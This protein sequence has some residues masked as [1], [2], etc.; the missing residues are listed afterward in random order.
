MESVVASSSYS[1]LTTSDL[2]GK[3]DF[4]LIHLL[5]VDWDQH[6]QE[7][8]WIP[9]AL[10]PRGYRG[11]SQ[12]LVSHAAS[13]LPDL[14]TYIDRNLSPYICTI[15][16]LLE[17][18]HTW[19]A[20]LEGKQVKWVVSK[21]FKAWITHF[22]MMIQ[23]EQFDAHVGQVFLR[24][25]FVGRKI[26]LALSYVHIGN[27]LCVERR[28]PLTINWEQMHSIQ[29]LIRKKTMRRYQRLRIIQFVFLSSYS[30]SN[31]DDLTRMT[32]SSFLLEFSASS[33][34]QSQDATPCLAN[35]I[36]DIYTIPS[37]PV[38]WPYPAHCS[39]SLTLV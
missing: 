27:I 19:G 35:E 29:P 24:L 22:W 2:D 25:L 3:W 23:I 38:R 20:N 33:G 30:T 32:G 10:Y 34:R 31:N 15:V 4:W 6:C 17:K 39:H 13:L 36:V 5:R 11:L 21:T 9:A 1:K 14:P 16:L 8:E 26:C 12:C 28:R 37:S 7:K 18:I